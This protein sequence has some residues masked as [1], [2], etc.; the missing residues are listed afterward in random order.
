MPLVHTVECLA[1]MRT[2]EHKVPPVDLR[3][4][5]DTAVGGCLASGAHSDPTSTAQKHN[6]RKVITTRTPLG[7]ISSASQ[8]LWPG[9]R[10]MEY[11]AGSV[12]GAMKAGSFASALLLYIPSAVLAVMMLI[13]FGERILCWLIFLLSTVLYVCKYVH[14]DISQ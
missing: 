9:S 6:I 11:I 2:E 5:F 1:A 7:L 14:L 10:T 8:V 3:I 12:E 13:A 4:P